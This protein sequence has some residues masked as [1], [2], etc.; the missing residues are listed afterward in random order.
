M[1]FP[2]SI[3]ESGV[4]GPSRT[5]LFPNVCWEPPSSEWFCRDELPSL[6]DSFAAV[7]KKGRE[8]QANYSVHERNWIVLNCISSSRPPKQSVVWIPCDKQKRGNETTEREPR[9]HVMTV[10][11]MKGN[12]KWRNEIDSWSNS[13]SKQRGNKTMKRSNKK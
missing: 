11:K 7:S 8:I 12:D 2:L 10:K 9:N 4:N 1:A 5:K 13:M 6:R 3:N